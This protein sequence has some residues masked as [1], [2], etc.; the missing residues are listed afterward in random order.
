MNPAE[1]ITA[2]E[3]DRDDLKS[4]LVVGITEAREVA[5]RHQI[6]SVGQE[7]TALYGLLPR[8]LPDLC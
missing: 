6:A 4:Q 2:L 8:S 7:I 5:I 1:K 3:K